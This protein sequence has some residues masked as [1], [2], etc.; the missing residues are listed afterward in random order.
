MVF[1]PFKADSDYFSADKQVMINLR[2]TDLDEFIAKLEADGIDVIVN[3]EWNAMPEVGRFAR[4]HDPDGN[5][6]EL[7]QPSNPA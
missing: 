3:D 6:I 4:I 5:P 1:E 7:W 2:V